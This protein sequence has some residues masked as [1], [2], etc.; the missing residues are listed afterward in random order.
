MKFLSLK[1]LFVYLLACLTG[2]WAYSKLR[3]HP[4]IAGKVADL[5]RRS[6]LVVGK[7]GDVARSAK[8]QAAT[9]AADVAE[10]AGTGAHDVIGATGA[11]A[12]E[13]LD[14][15]ADRARRVISPVRGKIAESRGEASTTVTTAPGEDRPVA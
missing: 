13:V 7:A 8:D 9:T 12:R 6:R 1:R 10:T 4:K 11:K 14:A 2:W 5:Q 3:N 15:T